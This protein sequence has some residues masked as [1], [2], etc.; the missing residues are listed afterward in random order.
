MLRI[1][2]GGTF[3][4]LHWGHIRPALALADELSAQAIHL[5]PSAIPP[6]RDTPSVS[7]EQRL[8]MVTLACALDSRL[9]AEDWE[10]QQNRHSYT[11]ITL[12]ELKQKYPQDTLVFALG[13]D[14]FNA[15]DSWHQWQQLVDHAHLVVMRRGDTERQLKPILSAFVTARE[16]ELSA[17]Q[18]QPAGG[19][20]FAQTPLVDIS[21][22]DIRQRINNSD[23]WTHMVPPAIADYINQQQL[24]R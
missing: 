10:L 24:Y 3:N 8:Q 23:N 18:Q 5:M 16:L 11:A 15:L 2:F 21:A 4:P 19:I 9:Q 22:T 6:H 17:L 7:P 14:A 20:Y 12:A 1:I 13:M